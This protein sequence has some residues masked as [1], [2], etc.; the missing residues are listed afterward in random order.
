MRSTGASSPNETLA[1]PSSGSPTAASANSKTT[2]PPPE[3]ASDSS[4]RTRTDDAHERPCLDHAADTAHVPHMPQPQKRAPT[5]QYA[6][7]TTD[8][9]GVAPDRGRRRSVVRAAAGGA[10]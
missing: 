5:R 9:P 1:P 8:N 10:F 6:E 7:S 4:S 2:S 3:T